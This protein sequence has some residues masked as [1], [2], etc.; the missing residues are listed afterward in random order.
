M[1]KAEVGNAQ[2]SSTELPQAY[3]EWPPT[4]VAGEGTT[5]F[6]LDTKNPDITLPSEVNV[7]Q[8][9]PRS[10]QTTSGTPITHLKPQIL[11]HL[12]P[13]QHRSCLS[14]TKAQL[15]V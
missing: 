4:P 14:Y 7:A 8:D 15:E 2:A 6:E 11:P 1:P 3:R 12:L 5:E 13:G 10:Q 9:T